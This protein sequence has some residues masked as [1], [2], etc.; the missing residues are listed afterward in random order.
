[1]QDLST[2]M[3]VV[4]RNGTKERVQFNKITNRICSQI[5]KDERDIL[6]SAIIAQ[7]VISSIY[8]GITTEELDAETAKICINMITVN[9]QYGG[10]A[11]RISVSNLHKKTL[12]SFVDKMNIINEQNQ[13]LLDQ[14]WLKWV[15]NHKIEL[16]NII[17][18]SRDYEFDFFGF[19]TLER[20]YLIRDL[21]TRKIYERPQDMFLRVASFICM[22]D[23]ELIKNTYDQLSTKKYIH[24]TPTNFNAGT[25]RPQLSSCFL[26]PFVDDSIDGIYD[27]LKNCAKISKWAGG[28]GLHASNIR[29]KGSSIRGT[30]GTSNGIIPML[31]VFNE[32]A[33]YVDQGGGKR[34]GSIAVYIEPHHSDIL[35]FLDL[36][37]NF[38][39]E[40]ERARDLFTALWVSDLFMEQV[41][42]DSEWYLMCPD[43]CPG[44]N[45]VYGD[46]YK[47]LYWKYVLEKKYRKK[48]Q[49]RELME[50]IMDS[51]LETGTP[52]ITYKDHVNRKSNQKNIGIIK[53][54]NLCVSGDTNIITDKGV[55][56]IEKLQNENIN[57]WNGFEFSK[58]TIYKT[59]EDKEMNLITFS[60]GEELYCTPE[61]KFYIK[62][63]YGNSSS[64]IEEVRCKD[65]QKDM[66][67]I[68]YNFPI[69][70]NIDKEF[71]YSYTHG[72]F[73]ADGTYDCEQEIIKQCTY[74]KFSQLI[75]NNNKCNG[76]TGVK[77]P[78]IYLY[79][80]KKKLLQFIEKRQDVNIIKDDKKITIYLPLN[81]ENKF[82][83]PI[84]YSINSRLRW[85]EGYCDGDGCVTLNKKYG[86]QSIQ[87][88]S[89]NKEFLLDIK[90]LLHTLGVNCKITKALNN[91]LVKLPDG[92][93]DEK[94][95]NC[96]TAYRLLLPS[97]EL[98]KLLDIGFNPKR[99]KINKVHKPDRQATEY[100]KI[101]S[102]KQNAIKGDT[103][104]FTEPKRHYGIFNGI[105]TGNCNEIVEVSNKEEHAVCNLG[106]IALPQFLIPFKSYRSWTI[107][108]K[109][110]CKYCRWSKKYMESKG[111]KFIEKT[112]IDDD[113]MTQIKKNTECETNTY[114]QIFYGK[115]Y[116]GGFEEMIQFT[117]DKY[118]YESLWKTAYIACSN[119]NR[120]I[121]RNY[122]P[123]PET[124][125]SNMRNRPIGLGIQG[126]ADVLARMKLCYETDKALKVN[127]NIM[128]T[129]YHAS[130]T[131]SNDEAKNRYCMAKHL[132][133]NCNS[134]P[135][136]YDKDYFVQ[137]STSINKKTQIETDNLENVY[138][139]KLGLTNRELQNLNKCYGAY[140]SYEGS[141]ISE[142]KFQ[143]D[144]WN[145]KGN[146]YNWDE[147]R[148]KI[149]EYGV[150]NSL[151]VALMPTAST[152]QIL[153][154]N[155][156]FEWFTNNILTRRTLAGDFP[157]VNK[158]LVN[159]LI[160]IGEWNKD[161]KQII[162][163]S[164]GSVKNLVNIPP[165]YKMLYKTIWEIKQIW[166]LKQA[167]ARAPFVDQTQSMNIFMPVPDYKKLLSCHM[168]GWKNGLKTGMY[169]LR[170]KAASSAV[171]F[172]VDPNIQKRLEQEDEICESCS[173]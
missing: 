87:C 17:D 63:K 82:V 143:F 77:R 4:K 59:G 141:P 19:K 125:C 92:K 71:N 116:I 129:I 66:K 142:G 161:T 135:E 147:L 15:N 170:S 1:M 85:F 9:P 165:Y 153:G 58:V 64:S 169:Y 6:D 99:L 55:F 164:D 127:S 157:L 159:D 32:T 139:H 134:L 107:Y 155:E 171:K 26:M 47:D 49:A 130:M 70:D 76:I 114:P 16:E 2:P 30:N 104:C 48:I 173:S 73:C 27:T 122:Y 69:I 72:F 115:Q 51:Q 38:G 40:T 42:T 108:T 22:G 150:R 24:A 44:L 160:A 138:Y 167:L 162:I 18:Y 62:T 103:F 46:E 41:Q 83:V 61:H 145:I 126:L 29:S 154:N 151:L 11:G 118:D 113:A 37:K 3:F 60:N 8:S 84:N 109:E 121:D 111:F 57:I 140:S 43:E 158:H 124:K 81:I 120:V 10:L 52:Y 172:T 7:K 39:A 25:S 67:I 65:L 144:M 133:Q 28:I 80:D 146:M 21:K 101:L 95:Y 54:S 96:K 149:I 12:N 106:S 56:P 91:R 112:E 68:K 86:T 33:R 119:L 74:N 89:I 5:R 163:A 117:C 94:L 168:W 88:A 102:I 34:K 50:K 156:C 128:E 13:G 90:K 166:V 36:R 93:G 75:T 78:K 20:S 97:S 148:E 79:D 132:K 53:S 23:I 35:E 152:S 45:E 98:T 100:I 131:A 110:K 136:Y 123:T 105:L 14:S 31:R 137:G